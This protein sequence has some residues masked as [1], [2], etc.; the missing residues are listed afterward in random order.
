MCVWFDEML[1]F[2]RNLS[3]CTSLELCTLRLL[4][5][6]C[7]CVCVCVSLAPGHLLCVSSYPVLV[8]VLVVLQ[9]SHVKD[10][11]A[12]A[13]RGI[14]KLPPEVCIILTEPSVEDAISSTRVQALMHTH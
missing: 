14:T 5:Q 9:P 6:V 10:Y 4:N 7:V 8:S 12:N 2:F 11:I 3:S 1:S 13:Q